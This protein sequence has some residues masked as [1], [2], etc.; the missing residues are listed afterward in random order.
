M[1]IGENGYGVFRGRIEIPSNSSK[2]DSDQ[3]CRTSMFG[4]TVR[5]IVIPALEV[6]A[7]DVQC[8]HGATFS[9]VDAEDLFYMAARGITPQVNFICYLIVFFHVV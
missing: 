7:S 8:T 9:N 3:L 4:E 1:F 6:S 2:T 5:A